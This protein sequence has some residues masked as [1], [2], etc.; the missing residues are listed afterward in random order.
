MHCDYT[1][2]TCTVYI[3]KE[4]QESHSKANEGGSVRGDEVKKELQPQRRYGEER[5]G[6]CPYSALRVILSTLTLTKEDATLQRRYFKG[7][8][9]PAVLRINYGERAKKSYRQESDGGL[10]VKW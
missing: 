1:G 7:A 5:D 10:D 4:L 6:D 2:R 8:L 3:S 9:W